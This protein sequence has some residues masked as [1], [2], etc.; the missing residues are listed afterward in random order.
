MSTTS[1]LRAEAVARVVVIGAG[2]TLLSDDGFGAAVL[3]ALRESWDLPPE[4]ELVD[5][6][7]WGM[8]LLPAIE[9]ADALV[10]VDAID[11]GRAPGSPITLERDS[12]P[13]LLGV[14]LSPHQI[15]LRETLA[16][17]ELRGRLPARAVAI[18]VQPQ[19]LATRI[20]LS[21]VVQARVRPTAALV[22]T[23]IARWGFPCRPA[24]AACTS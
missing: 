1:A 6:G 20:G 8:N 2:N 14:K 11:V 19:S 17:A 16:V 9:D 23:R 5:G 21:P 22:A 10:I 4:V 13:R 18:G 7:T 15:D 24:A 3:D 12:I